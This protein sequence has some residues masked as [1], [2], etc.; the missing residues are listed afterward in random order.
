M[1]KE[2]EELKKEMV[3][4]NSQLQ[5][6]K[7][8]ITKKVKESNNVKEEIIIINRKQIQ[9]KQKA[10]SKRVNNQNII[11]GLEKA[12]RELEKRNGTLRTINLQL[13]IK[14]HSTNRDLNSK[15]INNDH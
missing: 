11:K 7:D 4:I 8:E 3:N 6:R 5:Q 1:L 9:Q 12:G 14:L 15:S 13:E 2:N 10:A